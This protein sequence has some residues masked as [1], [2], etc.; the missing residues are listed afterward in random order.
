VVLDAAPALSIELAADGTHLDAAV[1]ARCRERPVP[2]E[3]LL[4]VTC[5][6]VGDLEQARAFGVDFA[7]VSPVRTGESP[8]LVSALGLPRLAELAA[9]VALPL[10]ALGGLGEA[11][12]PEVIATGCVGV[13]GSARLW[14]GDGP[15]DDASLAARLTASDGS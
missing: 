3:H 9:G 4:S 12:L 15:L 5:S 13:A 2:P 11:D 6:S 10:Y 7:F 14:H 8:A 1:L